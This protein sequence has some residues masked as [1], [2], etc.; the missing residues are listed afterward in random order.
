MEPMP[1]RLL[2]FSNPDRFV[3]G[4]IGVPGERAFFLQAREG[5][6]LASVGL[7]KVQMAVLAQRLEE[8]LDA[9]QAPSGEEA[10]RAPGLEEPLV[11]VFRVGAM[12][13]GWDA[14]SERVVIEATAMPTLT[15]EDDAP[16][17]ADDEL[18]LLRVSVTP[19]VA[20]AFAQ[21]ATRLV[22]AGRPTCPFCGEVLSEA[23]HFCPRTI[24]N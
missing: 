21:Q 7:E 5:R 10:A 19:A 13:L 14:A 16:P 12:T 3:P 9:V 1:R 4:T 6:A 2:D 17:P 8:L 24:L 20:R 23:A 22:A 15:G 11:E 18:D